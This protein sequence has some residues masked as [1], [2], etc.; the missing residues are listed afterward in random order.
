MISKLLKNFARGM[1]SWVHGNEIQMNILVRNGLC[2]ES[3]VFSCVLR[4]TK[5]SSQQCAHS[6]TKSVALN[7][8]VFSLLI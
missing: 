6:Y 1:N 3:F 8:L 5:Q 4:L 2:F 7:Y